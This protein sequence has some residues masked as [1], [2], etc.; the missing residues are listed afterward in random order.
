VARR[1]PPLIPL[2]KSGKIKH[3]GVSNHNM[4]EIAAA[5]EILGEAGFRLLADAGVP[6]PRRAPPL[7]TC[8]CRGG[9]PPHSPRLGIGGRRGDRPG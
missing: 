5:D 8:R 1:T 3:V 6:A 7:G 4:V 2:L 9:L